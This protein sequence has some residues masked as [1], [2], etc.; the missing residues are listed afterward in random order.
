MFEKINFFCLSDLH[1]WLE[2][3][4]WLLFNIDTVLMNLTS[5][6]IAALHYILLY[7][8][9]SSVSHVPLLLFFKFFFLSINCTT[10]ETDVWLSFVNMVIHCYH[11]YHK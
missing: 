1:K 6:Y 7:H 9:E 8:A 3:S 2:E 10:S 11:C 4:D 5:F